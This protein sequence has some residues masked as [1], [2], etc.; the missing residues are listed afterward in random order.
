MKTE[1]EEY[2]NEANILIAVEKIHRTDPA[3]GK[4]KNM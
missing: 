2:G 1:I 3:R 4:K